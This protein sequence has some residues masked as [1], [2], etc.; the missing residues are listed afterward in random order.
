MI[1]PLPGVVAVVA[2]HRIVLA[3]LAR[4]CRESSERTA[5]A[6]ERYDQRKAKQ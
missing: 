1:L 4:R 5:E 2:Q 3:D 6:L